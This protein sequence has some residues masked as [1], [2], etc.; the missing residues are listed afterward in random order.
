MAAFYMQSVGD[1]RNVRARDGPRCAATSHDFRVRWRGQKNTQPSISGN[2]TR[3]MAH[4]FSLRL[5]IARRLPIELSPLLVFY[6][7]NI[8]K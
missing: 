1:I 5:C 2:D 6:R 3:L 4:G 7:T 8:N